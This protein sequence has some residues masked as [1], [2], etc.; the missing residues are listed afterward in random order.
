MVS[1]E[2]NWIGESFS[3][4]SKNQKGRIRTSGGSQSWEWLSPFQVGCRVHGKRPQIVS[5]DQTELGDGSFGSSVRAEEESRSPEIQI[6]L[7]WK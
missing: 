5:T 6:C 3:R 2:S 4:A 7:V 1:T